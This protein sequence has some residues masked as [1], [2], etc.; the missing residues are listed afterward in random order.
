MGGNYILKINNLCNLNCCFCADPIETRLLSDFPYEKLIKGLKEKKEKFENLI[1]TGGEPT[2]YPQLIPLL[3]YAKEEC[4]YKQIFLTTNGVMLHLQAN[5]DKL[6]HAGVDTF[7]ISFP[8]S[9]EA[10]YDA[11]VK[12]KGSFRLAVEGIKNVKRRGKQVRVNTAMHKLNYRYLP[13]T[14][15]F[16][17][18]LGVDAIQL[19]F[20]NPIGSSMVN[21]KSAIALSYTQIMPTIDEAFIEAKKI[22]YEGLYIENIPACIASKYIPY[23]SDFRKPDENKDYYNASKAKPSQCSSC[24]MNS[25]CDGVWKDYL[26]QFGD[27]ELKPISSHDSKMIRERTKLLVIS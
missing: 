10:M 27:S 20:L 1:I 11:I 2:I 18:E 6:I 14:I 8:C 9:D 26:L 24:S 15:P 13:K 16:L 19:S 4:G 21:G 25:I 23:L 3:K 7:L 22:G 5:A 17:A 12:K